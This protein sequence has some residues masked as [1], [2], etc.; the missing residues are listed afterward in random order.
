MALL[1]TIVPTYNRAYCVTRAIDSA[2]GQSHREIEVIVLDDGSTDGTREM[3]AERYRGEPRVRYVRQENA[4]VSAA[5][6][7]ALRCAQGDYIALLDSD[8]WWQPWKSELQIRCLEA[9]P[10]VGM[11]WTDMEAVGSDGQVVHPRFLKK[12]Y[13][14]YG[15][16]P[17]TGLF[18]EQRVVRSF[19]PDAPA[20]CVAA[21]CSSGDIF[22]NMILGN[23][24]HTSTVM[25]T[26]ERFEKVSCFR[27]DLRISGEDYDFHLRTC[28][29]GPVAFLDVASIQYQIG[30]ADQLSRPEMGAWVAQNFLNTILPVIRRDRA[31]ITLPQSRIDN[32]LAESYS[33]A[34]EEMLKAGMPGARSAFWNAWR[35]R[36]RSR[37]AV[38]LLAAFLP[39]SLFSTLRTGYRSSKQAL[40]HGRGTTPQE[41][42]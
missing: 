16:I 2:L 1:S 38:C 30:R 15:D 31:R 14:A 37:T 29:E 24:V 12:M 34:G 6:N 19:W 21:A 18:S 20:C 7:A 5:R 39:I 36:R 8:D 17:E 27:E 28:R 33:W 13:S 35:L 22:S 32:L 3:I 9:L 26:R 25:L 10:G 42:A 11:V 4:G 40:R 23:L 41:A